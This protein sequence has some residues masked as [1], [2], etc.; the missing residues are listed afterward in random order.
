M[1]VFWKA[2]AWTAI[3]IVT[4]SV[5]NTAAAAGEISGA[6]L[7]LGSYLAYGAAGV[8]VVATIAIVVLYARHA[9]HPTFAGIPN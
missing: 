1:T 8:W 4:L 3:P 6:A 5:V 9:V 2:F 7:Q